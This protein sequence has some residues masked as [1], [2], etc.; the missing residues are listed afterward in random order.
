MLM[1]VADEALAGD[2]SRA[3]QHVALPV[4]VTSVYFDAAENSTRVVTIMPSF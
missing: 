1:A 2:I 4:H 3:G